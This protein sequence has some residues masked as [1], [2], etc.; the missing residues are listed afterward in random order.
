MQF[1]LLVLPTCLSSQKRTYGVA[2][3]ELAHIVCE[4]EASPANVTFK[5]I[6]TNSQNIT[7]LFNFVSNK[8]KSIISYRPRTRFD[9]GSLLC[10]AENEVGLQPNACVFNIIAEGKIKFN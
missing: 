9:Y 5:W 7:S 1:L 6:F 2:Q 8:T 10:L 3:Y 4:V